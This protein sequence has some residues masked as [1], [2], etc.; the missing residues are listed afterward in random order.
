MARSTGPIL[1]VGAITL[2][3]K[4]I[5]NQQ[6]MDWRIPIATGFAAGFFALLEKGW[7][8]GAVGL[9]WLALVVTILIPID[10]NTPSPIESLEK[11]VKGT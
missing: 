7:E 11:F 1:A 4:M 10:R 5:L 8:E 2:G 3:N 9:A 6:P